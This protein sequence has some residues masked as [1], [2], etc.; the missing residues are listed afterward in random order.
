MASKFFEH[1]VAITDA[2]NGVGGTGLW[3]EQDGFYYDQLHADGELQPLRVRS[4]VGLVPLFAVEVLEDAVIDRLPGFK[5][6]LS[7][8]L[9]NRA[10]LARHIS[11]LVP[12]HGGAGGCS[13]C[14]REI[15]F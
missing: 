10:D 5:Q 1:F 4:M 14:R 13:P 3:D 9:E 11:Y 6:R 15:G 2:M 8:F 7:W 12:A